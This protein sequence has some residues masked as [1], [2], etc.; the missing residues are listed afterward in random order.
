MICDFAQY[1]NIY[2]YKVLPLNY[3]ATLFFGLREESRS[4]LSLTKQKQNTEI[5]LL[6][7]IADLLNTLVWFNSEDGQKN[8]N[9]PKSIYEVLTGTDRKVKDEKI[10]SFSSAEEF[11]RERERKLNGN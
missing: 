2:D 4:K 11:E 7:L 3:V 6:G 1:Y 9:R 8:R 5:Q 10:L